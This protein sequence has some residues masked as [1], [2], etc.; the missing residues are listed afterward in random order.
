MGALLNISGYMYR[1]GG[2]SLESSPMERDL[3]VLINGKLS[4]VCPVAKR[5][6]WILGCIKHSTAS[7]S[8]EVIVPL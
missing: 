3:G 2:E 6:D 5:A 7:Q 8:R 1:M 4:T